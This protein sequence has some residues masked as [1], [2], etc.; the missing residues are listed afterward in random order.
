MRENDE[1]LRKFSFAA[2]LRV[3]HSLRV[4]G[5]AFDFG[6]CLFFQRFSPCL[7]GSVVK[8]NYAG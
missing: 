4:R 1:I 7:R 5:F 2:L 6:L 3:L 8:V